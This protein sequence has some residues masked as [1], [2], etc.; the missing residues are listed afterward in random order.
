MRYSEIIC[1]QQSLEEGFLDS[2]SNA[3]ANVAMRPIRAVN[4]AMTSLVVIK[5]VISDAKICES[6]CFILRK[7]II[8]MIKPF[9]KMVGD[10]LWKLV[11]KGYALMDFIGMLILMP[12]ATFIATQVKNLVGDTVT[13]TI[14][15]LV[16]KLTDL[17]SICSQIISTGAN[18]LFSAFQALG[19]ADDL[20]FQT[21]TAVNEKLN[22]VQIR[23]AQ[24][25]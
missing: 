25:A 4:N 12:A 20:L 11:P 2:V 9:P 14:Q 21:L 7:K 5:N 16:E 6:V 10:A 1:E 22:A 24:G 13:D 15:N 18:G 23:P 8:Q 3:V 17:R 19:L